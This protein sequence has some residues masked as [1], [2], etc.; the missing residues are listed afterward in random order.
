MNFID[1]HHKAFKYTTSA[2]DKCVEIYVF[3]NFIYWASGIQLPTE[4]SG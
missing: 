4:I 3:F 1:S 2:G